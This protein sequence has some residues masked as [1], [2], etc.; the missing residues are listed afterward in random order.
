[1][2][3]VAAAHARCCPSL[4]APHRERR[5]REVREGPTGCHREPTKMAL[6]QHLL[7]C[8]WAEETQRQES[9]LVQEVG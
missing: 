2:V 7:V 1:M 5:V 8:D 4:A 3:A 6:G 9:P